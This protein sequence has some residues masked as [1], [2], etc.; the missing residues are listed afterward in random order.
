MTKKGSNK[1]YRR[2]ASEERILQAARSLFLAR[3][4][5]GV[6]MDLIS[7]E[8]EVARQTIYNHFDNKEAVFRAAIATHWEALSTELTCHLSL[9]EEPETVLRDVAQQVLD[10]IQQHDQVAMTRMVIAES[11]SNPS[12][13]EMFF[14]LG[15]RPIRKQFI[16]YLTQASKRGALSCSQ[17]QIACDQYLG[18]IQESL[19]WPRVMGLAIQDLDDDNVVD[20]AISTF[21]ARYRAPSG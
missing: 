13:A 8:A 14:S 18:M 12:V 19:L 16:D 1:N 10:F 6:N 5:A 2:S 3:G 9:E 4:S 15:K 20:Q 7:A 17:P 21:M 11:F